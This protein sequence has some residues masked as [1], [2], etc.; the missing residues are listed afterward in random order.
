[1]LNEEQTWDEI[2]S[3]TERSVKRDF[4]AE[5]P[6]AL[7]KIKVEFLGVSAAKT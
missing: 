5:T 7:R 4:T 3:P 2:L 6:R 1:L